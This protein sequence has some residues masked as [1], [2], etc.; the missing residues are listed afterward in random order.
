MVTALL[1]KELSINRAAVQILGVLLFVVLTILGAFVRL[2]LGFTPVPLTLQTFFVLLSGLILGARAGAFSQI[3]YV[4]LGAAGIPLFVG[5]LAG[6]SYLMGP[7]GGYLLGFVLASLLLGIFSR[8]I[9]L[10]L[11]GTCLLAVAASFLI[12]ACGSLW[13]KIIYRFS[14]IQALSLGFMPFVLGDILKSFFAALI[15]NRIFKR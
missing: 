15:Y 14:L 6:I 9:N 4:S 8:K 11:V 13:L 5:G 3:I 12:L 10:N 1:R 7:T 2:P